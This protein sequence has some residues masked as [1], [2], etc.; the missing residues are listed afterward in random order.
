MK[1]LPKFLLALVLISG[2]LFANGLTFSATDGSGAE[3]WI[4]EGTKRATITNTTSKSIIIDG[5]RLTIPNK[6]GFSVTYPGDANVAGVNDGNGADR[7]DLRLINKQN[8][9][10]AGDTKTI[11]MN[12]SQWGFTGDWSPSHEQYLAKIGNWSSI[13]IVDTSILEITQLD[14][15]IREPWFYDSTLYI[16]DSL[17][18]RGGDSS[19]GIIDSWWD[20]EGDTAVWQIQVFPPDRVTKNEDLWNTPFQWNP[21]T[22][23]TETTSGRYAGS[24]PFYM[25]ALSMAQQ[26]MKVDMQLMAAMGV[27]ESNAGVGSYITENTDLWNGT[28]HWE[29]ATYGDII[30]PPFPKFF[31]YTSVSEERGGQ[32]FINTPGYGNNTVGNCPQLGNV[33]MI[34]SLYMMYIYQ[35][36]YSATSFDAAK[37]FYEAKDKEIA[38][39]LFAWA[40]NKGQNSAFINVLSDESAKTYDDLRDY[41]TAIRYFHGVFHQVDEFDRMNRLAASNGVLPSQGGVEVYDENITKLDVEEFYFGT[42]GNGSTGE[43]GTG[44]ILWHFDLTEELRMTLWN[45]L[46]SAFEIMKGKAYDAGIPNAEADKIT[47]RYDWLAILRI[48]QQYLDLDI[49]IPN[50]EQFKNWIGQHSNDTVSS[51]KDQG[52]E[53]IYPH[54]V[55]EGRKVTNGKMEVTFTVTDETYL[56]IDGTPT[57]EWTSD[58]NLGLWKPATFV[59]GDTLSATYKVSLTEDEVVAIAGETVVPS[60]VRGYDRNY[61]AIIDTFSL[62]WDIPKEPE[63]DSAIAID[64]DGD[65]SIDAIN[66]FMTKSAAPDADAL[67][68]VSTFNYSWPAK[69]AGKSGTPTVNNSV[70]TIRDGSLNGGEGEGE[71]T[72]DYPGKSGY[73][74]AVLDRIGPALVSAESFYS[75]SKENDTVQVVFT[76]P[77]GNS[78]NNNETYFTVIRG[79]NESDNVSKEVI[80]LDDK[81]YQIIFD[82]GTVIKDDSL[83]IVENGGVID[84]KDNK[85]H[86]DNRHVPITFVGVPAEVELDSAVA[87]DSDGDGSIDFIEVFV[88]KGPADDADEL[89]SVTNFKYS[90]PNKGATDDGTPTVTDSSLIITDGS[91]N[92]GAGEG[93][94]TFDYPSK[95]GYQAAVLDRIGPALVSARCLWS[96]TLENDT[97]EIEFTEDLGNS[98]NNNETYFTLIRGSDETAT[99]SKE[100]IRVDDS[101]FKIIFDHGTIENGDSLALV[102]NSGIEDTKGNRPHNE[103]RHVPV[104]IIGGKKPKFEQGQMFDS[105][106]DGDADSIEVIISLG[107]NEPETMYDLDSLFYSWPDKGNWI[108]ADGKE[109]NDTVLNI[110]GLSHSETKGDGELQLHFQSGTI[111]GTLEDRVGPVISEA[112]LWENHG[113]DDTLQVKFSEDVDGISNGDMVIALFGSDLQSK[114]AKRYIGGNVWLLTFDN[115]TIQL[116]DSVSIVANSSLE[117]S[118]GNRVHS[119]NRKEEVTLKLR[120]IGVSENGSGFFD[121]DSDGEMDLLILKMNSEVDDDRISSFEGVV[122]WENENGDVDSF[123]IENSLFDADGSDEVVVDLESFDFNGE[124]TSIDRVRYGQF[125][126]KQEDSDLP[127]GELNERVVNP[128]DMM[129][130]ILVETASYRGETLLEESSTITDT[131]I[132]TFSEEIKDPGINSNGDS[133]IFV[134]T[135]NNGEY[136]VNITGGSTVDGVTFEFLVES[137][138]NDVVIPTVHD[139]IKIEGNGQ[140]E[141]REGNSQNRETPFVPFDLVYLPAEYE[142]VVYPSPYVLNSSEPNELLE[143]Y[144]IPGDGRLAIMVRPYGD[145]AGEEMKGYLTLHDAVGNVV[146][147]RQEMELT[148][149]GA[150][151][152]HT[153]GTNTN[154]RELG[155]GAYR[156]YIYVISETDGQRHE[157]KFPIMIG[158]R[159]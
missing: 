65:G 69:G 80:K 21:K 117:D 62:F 46:D 144:D 39:K 122:V 141:D 59:S 54:L 123:H 27:K 137:D 23:G 34:S 84:A 36:M 91:L 133:T 138:S 114:I 90:W 92:G 158:I 147:D 74:S 89:N 120:P 87:L 63:L 129:A 17:G 136:R 55:N 15:L 31:P 38:A 119:E 85:P 1:S 76:E 47:F 7:Y 51:I 50:T 104:T 68:A 156:G 143:K 145:R 45:D 112:L 49:P 30:H 108:W 98:F 2:N 111:S 82:Y 73:Q 3:G 78:F 9:F 14:S 12:L 102:V 154:G 20:S 11:P 83:A 58:V 128:K 106:G 48:A 124:L 100:V 97:V 131:L 86:S 105:D 75:A 94:V 35:S 107:T 140:I 33:T 71:V 26:Y 99:E 159:K 77:L 130:P 132:V 24:G 40:W 96:E 155:S 93:E 127:D 142:I 134:L 16:P 25:M 153:D 43:L 8:N 28:M 18:I 118:A 61:N 146:A 4:G 88:Q 19:G 139:F 32:L 10:V 70:L 151:L 42:D 5:V 121:E 157:D 72:F 148:Y 53:D 125:I 149:R 110:S 135:G 113:G 57:V 29:T 116:G 44:G 37:Y 22:M 81:T 150:L 115:G 79:S 56:N 60:W 52:I 109:K 41:N 103:N 101:H 152:Y 95:S 126:L 6:P 66:V 67:D 64:E 13:K